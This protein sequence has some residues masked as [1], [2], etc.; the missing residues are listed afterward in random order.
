MTI[1][2]LKQ[3]SRGRKDMFSVDPRILKVAEGY[4]VRRINKEDPSYLQN[5]S[6]I[7]FEGVK[8]PLTVQKRDGQYFIVA[9]HIRYSIVMDLIEEG[10]FIESVPVRPVRMNQEQLTIDLITSNS[11]TPLNQIEQGEVFQRLYEL[12]NTIKEVSL[13]TGSTIPHI[14]NCTLLFSL[15]D[16]FKE[17]V[18]NEKISASL[19][20]QQARETKGSDKKVDEVALEK[21]VNRIVKRAQKEG[22][23][24]ATDKHA[25]SLKK[26]IPS[27][28]GTG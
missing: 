20:L 18:Y 25:K 12:G 6:S 17:M 7:I 27:G 13:K 3:V 1:K 5:R 16:K 14:A 8:D 4:N 19:L 2:T 15:S 9:G 21:K 26:A 10:E 24:K 28:I 23:R 22:K 11:K